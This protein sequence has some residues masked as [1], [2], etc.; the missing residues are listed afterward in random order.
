[1]ASHSAQLPPLE[2]LDMALDLLPPL[3]A[4][5][6]IPRLQNKPQN[7]II[8]TLHL[9]RDTHKAVANSGLLAIEI[10]LFQST[11]N[12]WEGIDVADIQLLDIWESAATDK[13]P[14]KVSRASY[15]RQGVLLRSY[16]FLSN[17]GIP[18]D[19]IQHEQLHL[20]FFLNNPPK[21]QLLRGASE[22]FESPSLSFAH[23][24]SLQP[25][26]QGPHEHRKY[27]SLET[28]LGVLKLTVTGASSTLHAW[29]DA[30]QSFDTRRTVSQKQGIIVVTGIDEIVSER[31]HPRYLPP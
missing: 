22:C 5:F 28:L 18:C 23:S 20:S 2:I 6:H 15:L 21:I 30:L 25:Q 8:D 13:R 24:T 3:N 9:W 16:S 4:R 11:P 31:F 10:A 1:M 19:L 29:N 17:P 14:M 27:V 7:P 12:D 26:L